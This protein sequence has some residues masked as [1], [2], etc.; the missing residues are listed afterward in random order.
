MLTF[1]ALL[2]LMLGLASCKNDKSNLPNDEKKTV[3]TY[4]GVSVKFPAPTLKSGLPDDYNKIGKWDGRDKIQT[5]KVYVVTDNTVINSTTFNESAFKSISGG[6]LTPILAVEAKAGEEV[7]AYVVIN[8]IKGKVTKALDALGAAEFYAEFAETVAKV[9]AIGDVAKTQA[10]TGSGYEDIV[11]MTNK[12]KP[13]PL[14][15]K[16]NVTE[17]Q[18]KDGTNNRINIEVTRVVSRG[19]VTMTDD[20]EK[21]KL[22]IIKKITTIAPDAGTTVQNKKTATVTIN[23]VDYQVTGSALQFNVLED[24]TTWIVPGPVYGYMPDPKDFKWTKLNPDAEGIISFKDEGGWKT[25]TKQKGNS[26]DNVTAALKAEDH[27]K[28]VLPVTHADGDYRKGNTTMFE[29]R[30]TFKAENN[31]SEFPDAEVLT[32]YSGDLFYGLTD[33]LFYSTRAKAE[34][35]DANHDG[36]SSHTK[37]QEVKEYKNGEMYY[38]IWLNPDVKYSD[39]KKKI[40]KSPVVRNQ[41]Y[42]AHITGFKELGLTGKEELNPDEVLET[43]KTH[44]SVAIKV[45]PWTLHGYEVEL[46][47]RY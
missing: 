41:V 4:V 46:G 39:L 34:S 16:A 17:E 11:V 29:I 1:G 27:S 28:F 33:G 47:N 18:A 2:A 44:L 24:A 20:S 3:D 43:E 12:D 8:D 10:K 45:L 30:A 23:A 35:M 7:K 13:S 25:V 15:V 40:S 36:S 38:Y 42:N 19:I 32:S 37:K 6:V 14:N 5:I 21:Q 9:T 31:I 26:K 22:E